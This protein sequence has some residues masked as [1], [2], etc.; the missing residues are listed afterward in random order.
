[1]DMTAQQKIVWLISLALTGYLLY[2]LAPILTPFVAAG[3]L[4][5]VGDPL[6][7][8][9]EK[10]R[11]SRTLA[12]V[13]YFLILVVV[14]AS[15]IGLIVPLV[16][17]QGAALASKVPGYIQW[18]EARFLPG[19][20]ARLGIEPDMNTTGLGA[21]LTEYG[22]KVAGVL[23]GALT[24]ISRSG[25]A[26][27]GAFATLFLIPILMFYL[28]RDWDILVERI[29]T[30]VPPAARE[31]VFTIARESD[32]MLGGF[33]RGQLLVMMALATLYSIGLAIVG[34]KYALAIG[35]IAGLVSFVPYLGL[36][37]G[38]ALAGM[39]ALVDMGSWT[40]VA[41]VVVVFVVSQMVEGSLL[42][43]KLVGDRIG[44]H[45]VLVIFA[46]LAGGQLFG[47]FGILLALPGAAVVSVI[48]RHF[49]S[50][51]L[52]V[53]PPASAPEPPPPMPPST[54]ELEDVEAAI[55]EDE[56]TAELAQL[57]PDE[58]DEP[59]VPGEEDRRG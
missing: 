28:L 4:A 6:V 54:E 13:V 17:E 37:V 58:A 9:L 26:V 52:V 25:T 27:I 42:T 1:M 57:T 46:V 53:Q 30:L 44:L 11:L 15:L 59:E 20:F 51:V 5:Y 55:L 40:A 36:F 19:L 35:V 2:L 43:P 23:T 41:G 31:P 22:D 18:V 8:R 49:Y 50:R 7:D 56:D 10:L 47:F 33:L 16:R 21:L 14:F 39:S 45:P 24:R 38:I 32:E 3:L 12:V 48:V 34:L 29:G